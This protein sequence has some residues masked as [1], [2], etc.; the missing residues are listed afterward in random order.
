MERM[1]N[2][3]FV[4]GNLGEKTGRIK[5]ENSMRII[6]NQLQ[7]HIHDVPIHFLP[8][9]NKSDFAE[10]KAMDEFADNCIYVVENLNFHPE[11]FGYIE[12]LADTKE[13]EAKDDQA[14][15]KKEETSQPVKDSKGGKTSKKEELSKPDSQ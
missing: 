5:G 14:E 15:E 13:P 12:P 6:Q 2:R 9:A 1:A 10:K 11:E 4:I 3:V 8:E 7:Q